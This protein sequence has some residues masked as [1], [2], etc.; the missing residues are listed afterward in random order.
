MY[1]NGYI[2]RYASILVIL[3]AAILSATTLLLQPAQERNVRIE[4]IQDILA[5]AHI[6]STPANAQALYE[7]HIIREI[8]INNQGEE[9]AVFGNGNFEKGDLRAFNIVLKT[10]LKKK[11]LAMAGKTAENPVFPLFVCQKD[12]ETIYIIPLYG[13]GLW[14]PVWGNI[15]LKSDFNTVEGVTFDH[16]G[17]TPG[18]G[19]EIAYAPFKNQFNNKTIFNAQGQFSSIQVVKGGVFNSNINPMHGV[20]AIS[21]GTIT[22]NGVSSMLKD[23]LENYVLYFKNQN[24]I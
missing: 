14:G 23:C 3:V 1:S 2:F 20:D 7:K 22:C 13:R 4:K 17:E 15:A 19:A 16:K 6:A 24:A 12:S 18:L 9:I 11:E 10:E 21:G 5:S 8:V